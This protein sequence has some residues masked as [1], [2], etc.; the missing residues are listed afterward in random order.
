MYGLRAVAAANVPSACLLRPSKFGVMPSTHFS[1]NTLTVLV[2][3]EIDCS[4]L[5]AINGMR[6]FNSKLPCVPPMVMAVSLPITW[7]PTC[8]TT[9]G[10]TGFTLPGMI[11][12]P[13]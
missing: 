8:M 12:E 1:L 3:S 2:S 7:A 4:R 5:R 13:F 6:T 9:S 11:D 10:I